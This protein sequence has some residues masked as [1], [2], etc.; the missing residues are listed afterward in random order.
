M[1]RIVPGSIDW[2]REDDGS[3][4]AFPPLSLAQSWLISYQQSRSPRCSLPCRRMQRD[5]KAGPL[6][7]CLVWVLEQELYLWKSRGTKEWWKQNRVKSD[8]LTA[9]PVLKFLKEIVMTGPE[10]DRSLLCFDVCRFSWR[11][12]LL[13]M[14]GLYLSVSPLHSTKMRI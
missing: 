11:R 14:W 1:R 10:Y 2:L 7:L 8:G 12:V 4:S 6:K 13:K 3:Y 5:S 9:K